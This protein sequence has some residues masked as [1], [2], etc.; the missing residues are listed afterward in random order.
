MD[1][2]AWDRVHLDVMSRR[3]VPYPVRSPNEQAVAPLGT[4]N[5]RDRLE[6]HSATADRPESAGNGIDDSIM[7]NNG[8]L[9]TGS[10][11][12]D[13][14]VS[15]L[16]GRG[17]VVIREEGREEGAVRE[18]AGDF[19][20]GE[21]SCRVELYG[22]ADIHF[23]AEANHSPPRLLLLPRLSNSPCLLISHALDTSHTVP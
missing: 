17:A 7:T 12:A 14:V 1:L 3:G 13:L 4:V 18:A 6:L 5:N 9:G 2:V 11:S 16:D 10:T 20:V 15:E 19:E 8:L 22:I 23:L 21:M